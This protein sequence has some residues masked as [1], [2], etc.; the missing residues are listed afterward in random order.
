MLRACGCCLLVIFS[1]AAFAQNPPASDPQAVSLAAQSIAALTGGTTIGDVTLT[2][3]VTWNGTNP[4]TGTATLRALGS[5]ESRMDLALTAGMRTE[6]RD[7]QTGVPLGQW[8]D[9]TNATGKFAFQNCWTDA[10]WFFPAL[11]SLACSRLECS[12]EAPSNEVPARDSEHCKRGKNYDDAADIFH[13]VTG[14][15]VL[16]NVGRPSVDTSS[17]SSSG[18]IHRI[19]GIPDQ[20]AALQGSTAI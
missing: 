7:A 8:T 11:G 12:I 17:T 4:D 3:N 19:S 1:C 5:G 13:R 14:P 20:L 6:I 18:R 10:V 15:L 16:R 9:P 2:G